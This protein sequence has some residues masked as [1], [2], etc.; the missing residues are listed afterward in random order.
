LGI[1]NLDYFILILQNYDV[2]FECIGG[3]TQNMQDFLS[4]YEALLEEHKNL[5]MEKELFEDDYDDI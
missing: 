3:E 2:Y 1:E 4:S 5:I